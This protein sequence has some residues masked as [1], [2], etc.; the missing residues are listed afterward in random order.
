MTT[1]IRFELNRRP[2][3]L[4]ADPQ[5]PLLWALRDRLQL[6]G[7]KPGCLQ[8]VCGACTVHLDGAPARA[9]QLPLAAVAGRAVITIEGLAEPLRARLEAGW[10]KHQALQCGYCQPGQAMTC[11][12]LLSA[13]AAPS[14]EAIE[15]ALAGHLCR[16]GTGPRVVKAVQSALAAPRG[17][18]A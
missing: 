14:A 11:A 2:V 15:A 16:C 7:T 6:K 18:A 3:Q 10:T 12:A 8:G 1:E 4:Q 17:S 5:M 9:C 13:P